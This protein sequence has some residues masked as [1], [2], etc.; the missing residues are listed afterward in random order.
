ME[1]GHGTTAKVGRW[2][3]GE[4]HV[5]TVAGE[6]SGEPGKGQNEPAVT[7]R[8]RGNRRRAG[9]RLVRRCLVNRGSSEQSIGEFFLQSVARE[10]TEIVS[11]TMADLQYYV[12][13]WRV[14]R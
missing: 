7:S 12:T 8:R 9:H 6:A 11:G 5:S 10:H 13:W 1:G 14:K 4:D 2:D 3:G